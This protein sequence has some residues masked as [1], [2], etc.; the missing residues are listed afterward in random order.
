MQLSDV[1]FVGFQSLENVPRYLAGM[2]VCLIP[3][4]QTEYIRSSF[5]LK[6]FEYLGAGKPVVAT[7]T[8]GFLPY[9]ELAYLSRNYKEF[10][11]CITKALEE[12]TSELVLRRMQLARENTWDQR[13]AYFSDIVNAFLDESRT[14]TTDDPLEAT[15]SRQG[16]NAATQTQ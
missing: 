6:F 9:E 5:S 15:S 14:A 10:E 7:W 11:E 1:R 12:D 16:F 3:L 4:R 2:D 13:V 8:E